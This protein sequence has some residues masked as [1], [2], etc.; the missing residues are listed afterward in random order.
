[1]TL[2]M[3]HKD[4]SLELSPYSFI[5]NL[6]LLKVPGRTRLFQQEVQS[7][8]ERL[9]DEAAARAAD[10]RSHGAHRWQKESGV[11]IDRYQPSGRTETQKHARVALDRGGF[12]CFAGTLV[13]FDDGSRNMTETN[14]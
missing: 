14:R 1:M 7:S 13:V 9:S 11:S 10:Y 4:H 6:Q 3:M 2:S 5:F 12:R 8:I